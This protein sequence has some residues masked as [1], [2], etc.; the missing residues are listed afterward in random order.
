M[1]RININNINNSNNSNNS[2]V[3]EGGGGRHN[4]RVEFIMLTLFLTSIGSFLCYT[5]SLISFTPSR[6][7]NNK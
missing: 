1:N 4:D 3:I 2:S 6:R 7:I 5:H